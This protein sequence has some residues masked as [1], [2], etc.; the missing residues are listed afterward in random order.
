MAAASSTPRCWV[1][2]PL[3]LFILLALSTL[4]LTG[5]TETS[6]RDLTRAATR[7]AS[8]AFSQRVGVASWNRGMVKGGRPRINVR[9]SRQKV[10]LVTR[11]EEEGVEEP[12]DVPDQLMELAERVKPRLK[13]CSI[14]LV[15]MMGSGKT[16]VG[17]V[18]HNALQYAFFDTDELV[19]ALTGKSIVELFNDE[20]EDYFRQLEEEVIQQLKAYTRI[21]VATGGGASKSLKNWDAMRNGL[22]VWLDAPNDILYE[23][24]SGPEAKLRPL[25][26][27]A[28][29]EGALQARISSLAAERRPLYDRADVRVSVEEGYENG[30]ISPATIAYRVLKEIER[31]IDEKDAKTEAQKQWTINTDNINTIMDD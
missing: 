25:L 14:Y 5:S 28:E 12:M 31:R 24:L 4:S 20:G 8:R 22:V 3:A 11:A 13:G 6:S 27:V 29:E 18:L 10:S 17:R 19:E 1:V 21:M 2:L 7:M 30:S 16:S 15:G 23:R 26:N 9:P